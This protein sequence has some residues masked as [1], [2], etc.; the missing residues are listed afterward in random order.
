ML[1]HLW[2]YA[3]VTFVLQLWIRCI[4]IC[5]CSS[6]ESHGGGYMHAMLSTE[7]WLC[8]RNLCLQFY[9]ILFF[10]QHF[11]SAGWNILQ[12]THYLGGE[13]YVFWGGREGYQTLLN[14]DMGR[15]MDHMVRLVWMYFSNVWLTCVLILAFDN[16]VP[17]QDTKDL[18]YFHVNC[19]LFLYIF[20]HGFNCY[21]SSLIKLSFI[22]S[23]ARFFEAAVAYKKKIG[24]NGT[25]LFNLLQC[26]I[27]DQSCDNMIIKEWNL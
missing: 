26:S 20:D 4:C 3:S 10:R 19:N 17:V 25:L 27:L 14:T 2:T 13:N 22:Y 7:I 8:A 15:E 5:C 9:F 18:Y 24:F 1:C 11:K 23:Q 12:V 6:Q 21:A 16:S